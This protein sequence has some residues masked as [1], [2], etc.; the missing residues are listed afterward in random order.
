V[1][2]LAERISVLKDPESYTTGE[3]EGEAA[4]REGWRDAWR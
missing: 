1:R 2:E 3:P 4:E